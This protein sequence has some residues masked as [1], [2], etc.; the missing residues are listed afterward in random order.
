MI[1]ARPSH[2]CLLF[3][4]VLFPCHSRANTITPSLTHCRLHLGSKFSPRH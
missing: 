4:S 1:P 3:S 2:I